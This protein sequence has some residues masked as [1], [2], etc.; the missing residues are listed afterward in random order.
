MKITDT[1]A[2]FCADISL[3]ALP[4]DVVERTPLLVLDLVGSI[5]RARKEAA[6]APPLRPTV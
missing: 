2:A 3:A 6:V 4:A 1:L 5:V